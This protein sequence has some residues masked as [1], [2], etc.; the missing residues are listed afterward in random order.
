[1]RALQTLLALVMLAACEPP[2]AL[3]QRVLRHGPSLQLELGRAG[4][5]WL[6]S[7]SSPT[8]ARNGA[9]TGRIDMSWRPSDR[10][11][12]G[13]A[14]TGSTKTAEHEQFATLTAGPTIYPIPHLGLFARL[15]AG[16][17]ARRSQGGCL[18]APAAC[19]PPYSTSSAVLLAISVGWVPVL[20][21]VLRP[22]MSVGYARTVAAVSQD[23]GELGWDAIRVGLGLVWTY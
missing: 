14:L 11:G 4:F 17:G 15:H 19:Q 23:T 20:P 7:G 21:T 3:A 16:I 18:D 8:F 12:L 5:K 22:S 1:M 13:V 6:S 10:L 9:W 2:E